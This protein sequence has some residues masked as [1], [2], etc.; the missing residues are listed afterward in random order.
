MLSSQQF[1]KQSEDNIQHLLFVDVVSK[2]EIRLLNW[3]WQ[4]DAGEMRAEREKEEKK[5]DTDGERRLHEFGDEVSEVGDAHL[6][7]F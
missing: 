2:L 5:S 7:H 4:R 1:V 3:Q 6:P